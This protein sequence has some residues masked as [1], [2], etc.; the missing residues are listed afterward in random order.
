MGKAAHGQRFQAP[1]KNPLQP[2]CFTR[3]ILPALYLN[4]AMV[5]LPWHWARIK[6][7]FWR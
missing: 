1:L 7:T 5:C 4:N 3:F 6:P 2:I